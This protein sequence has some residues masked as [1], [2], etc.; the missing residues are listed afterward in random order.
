M[1]LLQ[2]WNVWDAKKSIV[3]SI[4]SLCNFSVLDNNLLLLVITVSLFS[5]QLLM[6]QGAIIASRMMRP[7]VQGI[8]SSK[9]VPQTDVLSAPVTS[10]LPLYVI[11]SK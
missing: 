7:S 6:K 8:K 4:E 9:F 5:W 11:Y 2:R 3:V 1:V 10:H